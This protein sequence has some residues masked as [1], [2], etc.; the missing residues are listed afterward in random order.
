MVKRENYC[1]KIIQNCWRKWRDRTRGGTIER[2]QKALEE[3]N[4]ENPNSSN[5]EKPI[6]S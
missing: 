2:A 6:V 1:A 5:K 4:N 3:T